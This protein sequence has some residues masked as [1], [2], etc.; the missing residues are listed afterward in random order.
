MNQDFFRNNAEYI[1]W[2]IIVAVVVVVIGI[3][4]VYIYNSSSTEST[5]SPSEE[6]AQTQPTDSSTTTVET[7]SAANVL[8]GEEETVNVPNPLEGTYENP[9]E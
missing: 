9:F 6:S 7:G 3:G 8:P 4:A 1:K 5:E 2:G